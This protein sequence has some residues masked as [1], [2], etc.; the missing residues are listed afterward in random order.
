MRSLTKAQIERRSAVL[1]WMR[2]HPGEHFTPNRLRF[3]LANR[4]IGRRIS[5][6]VDTVQRDLRAMERAGS[7]RCERHPTEGHEWGGGRR[8]RYNGWII[9]PAVDPGDEGGGV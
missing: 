1:D 3:Y 2:L 8:I 9:T 7:V 5:V 4:T 6:T